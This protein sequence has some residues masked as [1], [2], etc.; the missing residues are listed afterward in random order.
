MGV[1]RNRRAECA[2]R[3]A[4]GPRNVA[5]TPKLP[6]LSGDWLAQP[7]GQSAEAD[8]HM[9]AKPPPSRPART[10]IEYP[11]LNSEVPEVGCRGLT[12]AQ[13]TTGGGQGHDIGA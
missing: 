13:S 6:S 10:G 1:S 8:R 7:L 3:L 2:R 12:L 4:R 11:G 5:G 9:A